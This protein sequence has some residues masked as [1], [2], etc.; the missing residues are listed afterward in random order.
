MEEI[1]GHDLIQPHAQRK[2]PFKCWSSCSGPCLVKLWVS[3]RNGQFTAALGS[4]SSAKPL[5]QWRTLPPT[6]TAWCL[7]CLSLAWK[8]PSACNV[9]DCL[10]TLS[11]VPF[12]PV[13][14]GS[15]FQRLCSSHCYCSHPVCLFVLFLP[16]TC[17]HQESCCGEFSWE[18][19][20]LMWQSS[21]LLLSFLQL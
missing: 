20:L 4:C 15:V 3:L 1:S 7:R 10:F 6:L 19:L 14:Q 18:W 9:T 21:P 2:V 16:C 13:C 12:H 8:G 17:K 5:S 11:F